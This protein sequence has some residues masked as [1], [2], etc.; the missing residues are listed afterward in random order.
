MVRMV[1]FLAYMGFIF[2]A[3]MLERAGVGGATLRWLYPVKIVVVAGLLLLFWR[4]YDELRAVRISFG[5]VAASVLA[6]VLV[7]VLWINLNANW[8]VVGQSAGF[9]PRD[10]GRIV[11]SLVFMR[12]AGAALVVP[13]MEE[14]F[15][16]S[17][18]MRWIVAEDFEK[19]VPRQVKLKSFVVTVILFGVEHNLWFA[20]VVAGSVYSMLYMRT[21]SLWSA[22]LAHGVTNGVLGLWIISTSNWA[23]W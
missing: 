8:M 1:P 14:L 9:D 3:D 18:L 4:Q 11:W 2:V 6:G 17:F 21:N 5:V 10:D 19:V 23:Y 13:V 12:L 16:R 20:G 7:F 15:W 22:I